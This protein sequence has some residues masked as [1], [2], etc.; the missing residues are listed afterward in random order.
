MSTTTTTTM[1]TVVTNHRGANR[2]NAASRHLRLT[3]YMLMGHRAHRGWNQRG[4]EK[5][6][7]MLNYFLSKRAKVLGYYSCYRVETTL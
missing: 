6:F 7:K 5:D 3:E 1:T 4:E 2:R